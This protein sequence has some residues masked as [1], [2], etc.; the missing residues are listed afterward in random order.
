[1]E[2]IKNVEEELFDL[3]K[4]EVRLCKKCSIEKNRKNI[5]LSPKL[6]NDYKK[7][8]IMF[9]FN[10]ISADEDKKGDLLI[11]EKNI[12]F[13]KFIKYANL[14]YNECYFTTLVKCSPYDN[15]LT[16]ENIKNCYP[17]LISQI[18][19][20]QPK[21][22]IAV[23]ENVSNKILNMNEDI[24]NLFGKSYDYMGIKVYPI[25]DRSYLPK[26]TDEEKWKIVRIFEKI[27]ELINKN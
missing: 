5:I 16:D 26:A 4:L 24:H 22:I 3:L 21:Y 12:Y 7:K 6:Q 2:Y 17:F 23:G 14:D 9:I 20:I 10:S 18:A 13:Q 27:N 8:K 15:N 1:M 19:L 11:D 25:F